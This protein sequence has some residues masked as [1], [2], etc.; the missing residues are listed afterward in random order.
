MKVWSGL[1]Q[2]VKGANGGLHEPGNYFPWLGKRLVA[3]KLRV[4]SAVW[5]V[6]PSETFKPVDDNEEFTE[7]LPL[8]RTRGWRNEVNL[9]VTSR[10]S[11]ETQMNVPVKSDA[12]RSRV[13]VLE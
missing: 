2:L 10:C 5:G 7:L 3:S 1:N 13:H 11:H 6:S 9:E 4:C 8:F 12:V